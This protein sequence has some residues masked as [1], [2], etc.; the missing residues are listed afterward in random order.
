MRSVNII[1]SVFL[2]TT[3]I[4]NKLTFCKPKGYKKSVT[5]FTSNDTYNKNVYLSYLPYPLKV[6][7][8][9][10]KKSTLQTLM[11]CPYDRQSEIGGHRDKAN[12][13]VRL[14]LM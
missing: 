2:N 1:C 6:T 9:S 10:K 12:S 3:K 4:M 14:I 5:T 11:L 8:L 13:C 7:H